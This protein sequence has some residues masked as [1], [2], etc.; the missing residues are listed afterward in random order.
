M[1]LLNLWAF[2]NG[3]FSSSLTR[4][5]KHGLDLEDRQMKELGLVLPLKEH[6]CPM[7]VIAVLLLSVWRVL[8]SVE[9]SLWW[10]DAPTEE[11]DEFTNDYANM[12]AC[13]SPDLTTT[14][15]QINQCRH[16]RQM[17]HFILFFLRRQ[18]F[19]L[20]F[21]HLYLNV[22]LYVMFKYICNINIYKCVCYIQMC[23]ITCILY[24]KCYIYY[25][26]YRMA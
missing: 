11:Q 24:H 2:N 3:H 15:V 14:W 25:P 26:N 9:W 21:T 10:K 17:E 4:C 16:C 1:S 8:I 5:H 19:R 7:W 13:F 23:Y 12:A 18:K 22:L 6:S 20:V